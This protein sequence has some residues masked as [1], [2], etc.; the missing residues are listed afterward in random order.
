METVRDVP[1]STQIWFVSD[2]H[3]YHGGTEYLDQFLQFIRTSAGTADEL[4]IVGDLFE[5]WIGPRQGALPF[6][7]PLLEEF[8]KLASSGTQ[9]KV[10]HGNR[11]FLMGRA[12]MNAGATLLPDEVTLK[13][14]EGLLHI[15]HGDQFCIH[16]RSYQIARV[17]MRSWPIRFIASILPVGFG[18]M[19]AR[20]YRKISEKKK[21]SSKQRGNGSRFHTI[22]DGIKEL[23]RKTPV[24]I[25]LCGHIHDYAERSLTISEHTCRIV[26][27]GAWEEGP[28]Y[29]ILSAGSLSLHRLE[30]TAKPAPPLV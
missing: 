14:A 15:S 7:E 2:I 29:A 22:E 6:Y 13:T 16:D 10:I 1:D 19:L 18:L 12:M 21:A 25:V 24:E 27:T 23:L 4:W 30:A 28:N 5:F 3:L 8:G 9:L 26:T 11:D 20:R 17:I